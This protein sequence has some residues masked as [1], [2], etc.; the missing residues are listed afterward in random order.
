[1]GVVARFKPL[2]A[3]LRLTLFPYYNHLNMTFLAYPLLVCLTILA[4]IWWG[5]VF[6]RLWAWF[7]APTFKLPELSVFTA[8]GLQLVVGLLYYTPATDVDFNAAALASSLKVSWFVL[9]TAWVVHRL[10]K[11]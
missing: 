9:V 3:T 2:A 4:L 5:W 11:S 7:V 10:E 6:T 8:I 1:M